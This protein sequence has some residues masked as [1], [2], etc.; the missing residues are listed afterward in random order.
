M[1][2]EILFPLFAAVTTLKGVGGRTAAALARL[3]I[4]TIADLVFHLPLAVIDRTPCPNIAAT[5]A[6]QVTTLK[7]RI[8]EHIPPNK[9]HL[10]YRLIGFD[11]SGHITLNFFN[12]RA[13]YLTRH[14]PSNVDLVISGMVELY[15]GERIMA[16]PDYVVP[17]AQ[18]ATIP[19]LEPVYS[20]TEGISNRQMRRFIS[21]A[22]AQ[23]PAMP[24][25]LEH[26]L[27]H[28]NN[29]PDWRQALLTLHN[30]SDSES[31]TPQH[32]AR[33]RLA[34]D[35]L[36]A[37]QLGLMVL[38]QYH[39]RSKGRALTGDAD[40]TQK[41]LAS[42]PF[43]LTTAQER[44]CQEISAD[45]ASD[46]R[47]VRL[48]QGDVGSG[49]TVVA[50]LAMLHATGS[51]AQ[52]AL[53]AP[54]DLLARQHHRN[55]TALLQPLG[56][57][58]GLLTSKLGTDDKRR[59]LAELASGN[60]SMVVGTHALL[61]EPVK[62]H[63]LAL[64]IV[65]EQH[66]FGVEQRVQLTNKGQGVALLSMTA[67]PIP[68]TLTLAHYGDMDLSL[69]DVKPSGRLPV[70]TRLFAN[71]RRDAVIEGLQRALAAGRQAY[72]VCPLVQES[73]QLDIADAT[74][75]AAELRAILGTEKVGLIHGQMPP[76]ERDSVMADFFAG[77]LQLLVATTVIEVGVDVPNASLMIIEHAERFGLAQ[78]HQLRGRVGRGAEQSHCCLLYQ[79]PL[80]P[81]ARERLQ[82][83]RATEDGFKLAEA[84]ARL[85]GFGELL[86]TKQSG[87]PE[88]RLA[89]LGTQAEL[90]DLA[91]SEA[92]AILDARPALDDDRGLALR[93]A[94]Y[95]FG[96]DRALKFLRSG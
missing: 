44:S 16:H 17:Q 72:W 35:E 34:Y 58:C 94:L 76:S 15:R 53:L 91:H 29:W 12:G 77:T 80:S 95:L 28:R 87:A 57:A 11:E 39:R 45:L 9:P 62:F 90:L 86:G 25:W 54:T 88:F 22:L 96:H 26:D 70:D 69:L 1:R 89:D 48:L 84:D 27:C 50:L 79:E 5:I 6:G 43:S 68:R 41:F 20:L 92:R 2:P 19:R 37:Q 24:E 10:P 56:L 23:L 78:L 49:K 61:Q 8:A 63:D 71:S 3:R 73:A 83:L 93:H 55:L 32:P 67:T 14:Y 30:P 60:L 18:S 81:P 59:T 66:R 38:R 13:D 7:L 40:L 64:V 85:R 21:L 52:A 82:T 74:A 31:C 75:R 4:H 33:Q 65:D 47:M 51:A 36:L 46:Q 42:L